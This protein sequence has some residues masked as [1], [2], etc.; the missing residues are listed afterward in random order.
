[1]SKPLHAAMI[2]LL[3]IVLSS[4]ETTPVEPAAEV[5]ANGN[6]PLRII[7]QANQAIY[8]DQRDLR[9]IEVDFA[10]R[11]AATLER[12]AEFV[13]LPWEQQIPALLRNDI[14]I[15]MSGLSITDERRR[16]IAFSEPYLTITLA[17][18]VRSDDYQRYR[19]SGG[20][21]PPFTKVG[22]QTATTGEEY[23]RRALPG[24]ATITL[25]NATAA[26]AELNRRSIDAFIHDSPVILWMTAEPDTRFSALRLPATDQLLAWGMRKEDLALQSAVD[27]QLVQWKRDGTLQR[28]LEKWLGTD[29]ESFLQ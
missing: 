9:G 22:V 14:D 27:A 28:M 17:A 25:A 8:T 6:P 16:Q 10:H 11:L 18:L 15:I 29:Y 20:Q 13:P 4:C 23:V 5:S 2:V 7:F 21:I 26:A 1:M 12:D 24:L 19:K 3:S